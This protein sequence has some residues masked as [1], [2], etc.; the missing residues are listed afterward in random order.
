MPENPFDSIESARTYVRLLREQVEEVASAVDAD[1][2]TLAPV[3][4]RRLDALRLVK[5]KLAELHKH[6]QAS[7]RT[8]NDLRALHRILTGDRS[9]APYDPA[10]DRP[11]P[12]NAPSVAASRAVTQSGV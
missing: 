8:L 10:E 4:S 11:A 5:F 9:D 2:D 1:I 6:L 12:H 3:A 7:S